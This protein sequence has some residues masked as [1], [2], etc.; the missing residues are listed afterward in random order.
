MATTTMPAAF[1]GHGI[2]GE[3]VAG[4][5]GVQEARYAFRLPSRHALGP[6]APSSRSLLGAISPTSSKAILILLLFVGAAIV[7]VIVVVR[8]SGHLP[9]LRRLRRLRQ[10]IVTGIGW[11]R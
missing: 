5:G 9:R 7:A 1:V 11:P 3:A 10:R 4:S 8:G 6:V 2:H